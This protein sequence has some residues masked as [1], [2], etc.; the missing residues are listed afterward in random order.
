[1]AK[2]ELDRDSL[3][4]FIDCS[5]VCSRTVSFSKDKTVSLVRMVEAKGAYSFG[6]PLRIT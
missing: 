6:N 5:L 3:T 1:M 4:S 2:A